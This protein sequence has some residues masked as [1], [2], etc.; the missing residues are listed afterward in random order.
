VVGSDLDLAV[1]SLGHVAPRVRRHATDLIASHA[2]REQAIA[3][4]APLL[5]DPSPRVVANAGR[6]LADLYAPDT[7]WESAWQSPEPT[8]RR[9]AWRH[10]HDRGGW[11]RL[12]ADLRAATDPDRTLASLGRAGVTS[13]LDG[14]ANV[15]ST[16]RAAQRERV[17]RLLDAVELE[18]HVRAELDFH[19]K[20]R[21]IPRPSSISTVLC[22]PATPV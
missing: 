16:P 4:I 2:P 20:E 15:W 13:W 12:E 22:A 11:D 10:T 14:A 17:L 7:V 21:P 1:E 19:L 8:T 3:L 9:V 5:R 18:S 6:R